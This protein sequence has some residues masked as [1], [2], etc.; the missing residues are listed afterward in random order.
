M[1]ADETPRQK[2]HASKPDSSFSIAEK[3]RRSRCIS[4]RSFGCRCPVA[5]RPIER[6]LCTSGSSRHSRKTPCPTIP[7]APK[8][9]TFICS[10]PP[11]QHVTDYVRAAQS[12][13]VDQV[14]DARAAQHQTF[15]RFPVPEQ[16]RT[17]QRRAVVGHSVN[18]GA[19]IGQHVD[20]V[21]L[22]ARQVWV[23]AGDRQAQGRVGNTV[24]GRYRVG[25]GARLQKDTRDCGR[26]L[27]RALHLHAIG[28]DIVE[29]SGLVGEGSALMDQAGV[30]L[31]Q[32]AEAGFVVGGDGVY[33]LRKGGSSA[34][35]FPCAGS[36][37]ARIWSAATLCNTW[38]MRLGHLISISRI[39]FEAPS[40]KCTRESL[41]QAE[42]TAVGTSLYCFAPCSP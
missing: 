4:S 35:G 5:L 8:R 22:N 15:G 31:E 11:F 29:K 13:G 40:P 32:R 28:G 33:S 1:P 7:V 30:G 2:K 17:P 14:V 18:L 37:I 21:C 9:R 6:T 27:G 24:D 39:V 10:P 36:S 19:M 25:L 3:S 34:H 23:D 42:P 16:Q 12:R 38:W 26:V 41:A 20:Q